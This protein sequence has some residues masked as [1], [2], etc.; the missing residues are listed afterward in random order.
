MRPVVSG[1]QKG[2][3]KPDARRLAS[4]LKGEV[5]L[6]RLD[7]LLK[8][9]TTLNDR[10]TGIITIRSDIPVTPLATGIKIDDRIPSQRFRQLNAHRIHATQLHHPGRNQHQ[11][12]T[13]D[14]ADIPDL[15]VITAVIHHQIL[16]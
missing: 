10:V 14:I 9:F 12:I 4:G 11:A 5:E 15:H 1:F 8:A 2:L 3:K 6:Q 13:A 7:Q 16:G